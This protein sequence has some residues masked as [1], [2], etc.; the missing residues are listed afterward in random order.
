MPMIDLFR[1]PASSRKG[2]AG[3][4]STWIVTIATQLN[5]N[6][7]PSPFE[8][9]PHSFLGAQ[10]EVD[11]ATLEPDDGG[12]GFDANGANGHGGVA[13]L[14]QVYVAPAPTLT[15]AVDISE[16]DAF[17]VLVYRDADRWRLA[18]AIELVSP[19]NKDRPEARRA[20]AMKCARYLAT[21][22]SLV[23]IDTV[24]V[25]SANLHAELVELCSMP[26]AIAWQSDTNLSAI[27]YR[28]RKVNDQIRLDAWPRRL[29]LGSDLPTLPL[30]LAV[31]LAV[32]LELEPTYQA[33]RRA[34]KLV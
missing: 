13:T 27:S 3:F 12:F 30:W 2:W 33:A 7:L 8:A 9:E 32:P 10:I 28:T 24:T 15:A 22:V 11:V 1:P 5:G 4:H 17:E 31:D 23:V 26:D 21:G 14:P 6:G 29:E 20:F 18:A 34:L 25:R 16:I 19:S